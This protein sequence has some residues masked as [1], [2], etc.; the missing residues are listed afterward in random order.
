VQSERYLF[1]CQRY[2]ELN[3]VRAGIVAAPAEFP[4]SSHRFYAE[5]RPDDAVSPHRLYRGL[6]RDADARRAAYLALFEDA[7]ARETLQQIRHCVNT[8]WALGTGSFCDQLE[9]ASGRPARPRMRGALKRSGDAVTT[10]PK[11]I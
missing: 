11:I 7:I 8:G 3:P 4:W 10:H 9:K 1:T 2:I 6:G 5:D